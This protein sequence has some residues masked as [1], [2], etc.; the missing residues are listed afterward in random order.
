MRNE[1]ASSSKHLNHSPKTTL[2]T[3]KQRT[4]TPCSDSR[5]KINIHHTLF[6]KT[7]VHASL[8]T[9]ETS[10][11][12]K[13]CTDEHEDTTK[14]SEPARHLVAH[15]HHIFSWKPILSVHSWKWHCAQLKLFSSLPYIL[16]Y[17]S[18]ACISRTLFLKPKIQ[19]F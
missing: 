1:A 8:N 13:A 15:P 11:N 18:N 4:L 2:F 9:F 10:R 7:H 5:I 16:V 17:K 3:G 12:L 14:Q 6:T 19:L